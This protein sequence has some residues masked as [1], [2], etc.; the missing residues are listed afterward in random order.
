M[1]RLLDRLKRMVPGWRR[2]RAA[3]A[4]SAD[5]AFTLI[6]EF[7]DGAYDVARHRALAERRGKMIDAGR[8]AGHWDQARA[9]I[10]HRTNRQRTD[11][12]TPYGGK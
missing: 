1:R 12:A 7:G 5:D 4:L 11:T 2:H 9:E 8:E 10:G 3:R 6:A